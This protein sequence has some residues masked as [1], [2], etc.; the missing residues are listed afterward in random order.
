[1][2]G[3]KSRFKPV[4]QP[5]SF[6]DTKVQN[7]IPYYYVV[8]I[9]CYGLP[10]PQ[11]AYSSYSTPISAIAVDNLRPDTVQNLQGVY[12]P[13]TRTI[14]ITWNPPSAPDI[15]GYWVCPE[16]IDERYTLAHS[17]P[18]THTIYYWPLP[19]GW[20]DSVPAGIAVAAMDHSGH[21]SDWVL[22]YVQLRPSIGLSDNPS[23]TGLN[24][25]PKLVYDNSRNLL[26]TAYA[27]ENTIY[28]KN[29]A[30]EGVTWRN[31]V[32]LGAG[33]YPALT[34]DKA[35]E[36]HCTWVNLSPALFDPIYLGKF[37]IP[38]IQYRWEL[39]YRWTQSGQ[40]LSNT[41]ILDV[42]EK[43]PQFPG[44]MVFS[45]PCIAITNDSVHI[46]MEKISY[47]QSVLGWRWLWELCYYSFPKGQPQLLNYAVLDSACEYIYPPVE[48]P[49]ALVRISDP[50]VVAD[51]YNNLHIAYTICSQIRYQ[52]KVGANW[53]GPQ[54][55]SPSGIHA[56]PAIGINGDE[57][58][59]V[60]S[61]N[62]IPGSG[63]QILS[64]R[65]FVTNGR[66]G[67]IE[68]IDKGENISIFP[69]C[70][71]NQILWTEQVDDTNYE[72]YYSRLSG[73]TWTVP[74]NLSKT[75]TRSI[76]AQAAFQREPRKST[77]YYI[78]T[79]G[80]NAPY[81]LFSG[82][83]VI[84][85]EE[86]PV[87]AVHL[88][89]E[90]SS[91]TTFAR[92][93]F[94]VYGDEAYKQVDWDSTKLVYLLTG[95][96]PTCKYEIQWDWY[97]ESNGNWRQRLRIDNIFNAQKW[98]V[99]GQL[100]TMRKPIPQAVL[101]DGIMEITNEITSNNGLAILSGF[102]IFD[103]TKGGGGPQSEGVSGFT[104]EAVRLLPVYPNPMKGMLKIRFI[105]PDEQKV[106]IKLYDVTGRLVR[107]LFDNKAIRGMNEILLKP[108][109]LSWGVY[110]IH[111]EA[112]DYK[113]VEKV[114]LVR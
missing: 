106:T 78:F 26:H 47:A 20:P 13:T 98:V 21:I 40:W 93:G 34:K 105:A 66:W 32:V 4:G 84:I 107:V 73:Y 60:W 67:N 27:S 19:A 104:P 59:V 62:S 75:P 90:T 92:D 37:I 68:R 81:Y 11:L 77:L 49:E 114:I 45:A 87:Y 85:A 94:I 91:S 14:R 52:N 2:C 25:A 48:V 41:T 12:D 70:V 110:F 31:E 7:G 35:N 10:I 5:Y 44:S 88:G 102:A 82:K 16:P 38:G 95:F 111:L 23:A 63:T 86:I 69:V 101:H 96:E 46:L 53:S 43:T 56:Q 112:E 18:V 1:V 39:K 97:H 72:I 108:D 6:I 99:P 76:F 24:N 30:D 61:G 71:A 74:E 15:A 54:V 8:R 57:I 55:I 64:R 80:N 3:C 36:L 100:V 103:A 42:F 22:R 9:G 28:Y 65:R 51:K 17:S 50:S 83:K 58:M 113:M 33:F 89:A 79:D 109:G 29:S